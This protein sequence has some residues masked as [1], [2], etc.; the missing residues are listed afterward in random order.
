MKVN[1][2]KR[3]AGRSENIRKKK[4]CR[5]ATICTTCFDICTHGFALCRNQPFT[6]FFYMSSANIHS[7]VHLVTDRNKFCYE[8]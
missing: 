5:H 6:F 7:N 4:R 3:L 8:F 2:T 1:E